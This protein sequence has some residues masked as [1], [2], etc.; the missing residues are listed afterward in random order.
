MAKFREAETRLL[1]KNICMKCYSKNPVR[2][3]RCRR[4]GYDGLR[5]KAKE[6]R[7]GA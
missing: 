3:V 4:C 7:G 2:A 1:S 6:S 5:P